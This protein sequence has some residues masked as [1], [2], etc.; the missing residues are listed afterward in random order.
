M[1]LCFLFLILLL[2]FK[3]LFLDENTS[4]FVNSKLYIFL[5]IGNV[6]SMD[7]ESCNSK[8]EFKISVWFG[9]KNINFIVRKMWVWVH[10]LKGARI[11]C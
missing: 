6:D 8:T 3:N 7:F 9:E 4:S 11:I 2:G 10:A 1:L 5:K